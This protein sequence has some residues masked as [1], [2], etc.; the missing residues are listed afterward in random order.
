[1]ESDMASDYNPRVIF[2]VERI[3]L[4][5]TINIEGH[6]DALICKYDEEGNYLV[7]GC[8]DGSIKALSTNDKCTNRSM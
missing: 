8:K 3:F 4:E 5:K 6:T 2:P 1:M 7:L